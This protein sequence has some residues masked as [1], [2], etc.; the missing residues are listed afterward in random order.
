MDGKP[1]ALGN[2]GQL[3]FQQVSYKLGLP[4]LMPVQLVTLIFSIDNSFMT[5]D[6]SEEE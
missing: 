1:V 6:T 5:R 4:L 2:V 3:N